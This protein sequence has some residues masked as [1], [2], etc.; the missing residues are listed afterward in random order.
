MT[1]ARVALDRVSKSNEAPRKKKGH[2]ARI[3]LAG[4]GGGPWQKVACKR[5]ARDAGSKS[6]FL[7]RVAKEKANAREEA[8][9]GEEDDDQRSETGESF[10][11]GEREREKRKKVQRGHKGGGTKEVRKTSTGFVNQRDFK[12]T[13][14]A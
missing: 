7:E 5:H 2:L 13:R 3:T 10:E 8:K 14:A 11:A 6:R 12:A 4:E 1:R 9:A